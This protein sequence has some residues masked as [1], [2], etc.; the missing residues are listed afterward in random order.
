M[1]NVATIPTS[2]ITNAK[3]KKEY[4]V[5]PMSYLDEELIEDIYDA[6]QAKQKLKSGTFIKLK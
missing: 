3:G 4:L 1:A 6:M 2:F 5:L